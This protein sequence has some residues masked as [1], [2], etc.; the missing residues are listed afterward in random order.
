MN[1]LYECVIFGLLHVSPALYTVYGKLTGIVFK[2]LYVRIF[3]FILCWPLCFSLAQNQIQS[4]I[5]LLNKGDFYILFYIRII[6]RCIRDPRIL[7]WIDFQKLKQILGRRLYR[8]LKRIRLAFL[9]STVF[10]L[11][12]IP[13]GVVIVS[14]SFTENSRS[15]VVN[16]NLGSPEKTLQTWFEGLFN[17]FHPIFYLYTHHHSRLTTFFRVCQRRMRRQQNTPH[18][19][20]ARAISAIALETFEASG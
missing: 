16:Y 5:P 14:R 8:D 4:I 11:I 15:T 1:L 3:I 19:Q 9:Y 2:L 20:E 12:W 18:S 6:F 13:Y 17:T 10:A 7:N